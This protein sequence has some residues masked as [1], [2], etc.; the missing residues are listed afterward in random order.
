MMQINKFLNLKINNKLVKIDDN[1]FFYKL[2]KSL[3]YIFS[4]ED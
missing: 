2:L 1:I 3:N 4:V